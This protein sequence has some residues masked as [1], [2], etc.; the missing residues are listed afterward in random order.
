MKRMDVFKWNLALSTLFLGPLAG[1][2]S[3]QSWTFGSSLD[4]FTLEKRG[5]A[6]FVG[7]KPAELGTFQQFIP[8]FSAPVEGDCDNLPPKPDLTVKAKDAAMKTTVRHFYIEKT[9]IREGDQCAPIEGSGLHYLPLH[10]IWFVGKKSAQINLGDEFTFFRN[11]DP[12]LHFK[13]KN[14]KWEN[15]QPH[16]FVDWDY[17]KRFY[18]H[19]SPFSIDAR[20][21]LKMAEGK[22]HI[23]L[24]T[25]SRTYDFYKVTDR[26][27][28]IKMPK[29]H[30]LS[31]STQW[32]FWKDFEL[33]QWEDRHSQVLKTI[34]DKNKPLDVR[35]EALRELGDNWSLPIKAAFH[36]ILLDE[37]DSPRIKSDVLHKIKTHPSDENIQVLVKS[38]DLTEDQNLLSQMTRILRFRNPK[39]PTINEKDSEEDVSKKIRTWKKWH[40]QFSSKSTQK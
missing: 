4:Y 23:Q 12:L 1:A 20:V 29:S 37:E 13:K 34:T 19:L 36:Q 27:W 18:D 17:F 32:N 33:S 28:A 26:L 16:L 15:E 5:G 38:L 22:P 6:Y 30:W 2:Q 7:D 14:G 3:F 11:D 9:L 25:N 24:K 21:N 31:I 40:F 10:R 39:G 35:R 8:L